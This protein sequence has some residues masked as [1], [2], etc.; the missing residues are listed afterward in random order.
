MTGQTISADNSD[1]P[2]ELRQAYKET[3]FI[4]FVEPQ[5]T[6][7]VEKHSE[8]LSNLFATQHFTSAAFI[9]AYNPFS[10]QLCEKENLARQLK[11]K[12]EIESR[13]LNFLTGV[14]QHPS[15]QW[16][17]EPSFLILN[18]AFEAAK[19]LSREYDQNAFVWSDQSCI[20]R[21]VF[22]FS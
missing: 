14:G 22:S 5:I 10:K 16:E 18:I 20:P 11:L 1:I 12:K 9:T 13:G 15:Q 3:D 6:L 21:L 4:I 7:H 17:R 19:K 8:S 2:D